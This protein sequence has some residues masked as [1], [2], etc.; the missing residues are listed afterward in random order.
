VSY[1]LEK[2]VHDLHRNVARLRAKVNQI[3]RRMDEQAA[4]LH[5]LYPDL[6]IFTDD[7]I[8][9]KKGE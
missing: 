4:L 3:T 7:D 1:E 8:I 2:Q 5:K 9:E 6:Q